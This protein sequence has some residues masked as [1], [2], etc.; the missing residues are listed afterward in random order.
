MSSNSTQTNLRVT[1]EKRPPADTYDR[2]VEDTRIIGNPRNLE[3]II[4]RTQRALWR[5][6]LPQRLMSLTPVYCLEADEALFMQEIHDKAEAE[7]LGR[8]R[9]LQAMCPHMTRSFFPLAAASNAKRG[10]VRTL[11]PL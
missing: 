11:Q 4:I 1:A 5:G 3:R 9:T 7:Y 6:S 10:E 2:V 8:Q